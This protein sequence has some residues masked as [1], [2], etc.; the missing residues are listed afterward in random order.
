MTGQSQIRRR[1]SQPESIKR[2]RQ[3]IA[4][5]PGM[6]RSELADRLCDEFGFVD[7]RGRRQHSGCVKALRVLEG[8]GHFVLPE[9]RTVSG[10]PQPRRLGSGVPPPQAVPKIVGEVLALQLQLVETEEQMRLWN[11]LFHDEHPQGDGPLVGRQLRYL[12][13]SEH[14]W[15]GGMGFASAALHLEA[16]D[17]WIGWGAESRG[18]HLDRVVAMSRF[19]I[20]P[21]VDCQN[22]ASHVLSLAMVRMPQDF[23]ARYGYCPWL[24]ETFVDTSQY[25]G[26]C[27]RAANWTRVGSTVGRGRQDRE[28]EYAKTIKDIYV[29]VVAKNFRSHL[30]LPAHAGRGP[31]PLGTGLD[32]ETWTQLEFGDAPLGDKRL[33]KRVVK[34]VAELAENP[35][36]S[37]AGASGGDTALIQGHYRF[38]EQPDDSAVTMENILLPHREQTIRRMKAQK[39]ALCIQDGSDLDYNG[40]NNCTGLGV[41]GSNQTGAQSRGLHLH[42]TKV[43]NDSGLPLGVLRAHC[44]APQPKPETET[45]K[46]C[47]IPIEEK[48]TY[49]WIVGMRDCEAVAADMP[50][51]HIYQV[52]DR[53]AD[54]FELFDAWRDGPRRTDLLVRANHNR[55]TTDEELKLFDAAR[56]AIPSLRL[57]LCIK[58]Q[59]ARPKKSKQKARP[60]R[61]ERTAEVTL[62]YRQVELRPPDYLRHKKPMT[63]WVVHLVEETP[64]EGVDPIEWFLLTTREVTTGE[65][66]NSLVEYYC[67]RWRIEDFHRVLKSGCGIEELRNDTAERLKRAIAIY[68]VIAWRIMLMTLLGREV[69]ELP[70]DV[71]FSDIELKML[72]AFAN[73]RPDLKPPNSLGLPCSWWEDSEGTRGARTILRQATRCSGEAT[74]RYGTCVRGICSWR[75]Q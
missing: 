20:R 69:P 24:V 63:L 19:L 34:S 52:M 40:A 62:R 70:P 8:R 29:W 5:R 14:G 27:Y 35:R 3:H 4:E 66:A 12:I 43:V 23:E 64:P 45:R 41:I 30:G 21:S 16:R 32:P 44:W 37:F 67:L 75:A 13:A 53:E 1:L 26:T 6:H 73:S 28:K 51:T 65:Q 7:A 25:A 58:R 54:F 22:L 33:S 48:E 17:K 2:V 50:H 10:P 31:L 11:Q 57:Q 47:D 72:E 68:M 74:Q 55:R 56:A 9:R 15:L 71:L 18:T 42:S 60:A 59:S 38:I 49:T 46:T 36:A 39:V 61:I